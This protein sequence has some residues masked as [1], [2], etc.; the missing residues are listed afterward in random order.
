VGYIGG[1]AILGVFA[2]NLRKLI[3]KDNID[4]PDMTHNGNMGGMSNI[5]MQ[6]SK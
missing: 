3:R 5:K 1:L 6:K 2:K 4:N